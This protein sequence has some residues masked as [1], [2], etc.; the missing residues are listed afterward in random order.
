MKKTIIVCLL[1]SLSFFACAETENKR[2]NVEKL[3]LLM[4]VDAV[5][6][7]M[8]SQMDQAL[9]GMAQQM[10]VSQ[11]DREIFERHMAKMIAVMKE[12]MSWEKMQQPMVD[13]YT[14]HYNE[15]EIQDLIAFYKSET[16]RSMLEKMPAIAR[17][18]AFIAQ[19][20]M[21]D[22]IPKI[23]V[24]SKELEAELMAFRETEK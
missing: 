9:Q 6:E 1:S 8:Y 14:K 11:S 5:V 12:E 16:G 15:R 7:I 20:L 21:A 10:G 17:D 24:L 18:S 13:L 3:L 22:F 2:E 23:D 19:S 4:D